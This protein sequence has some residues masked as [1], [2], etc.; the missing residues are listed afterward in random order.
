MEF[1]SL[2]GL[3]NQNFLLLNSEKDL[4]ASKSGFEFLV[5]FG[6]QKF[7]FEITNLYLPFENTSSSANRQHLIIKFYSELILFELFINCVLQVLG[8]YWASIIS[9]KPVRKDEIPSEIFEIS[10][11]PL[12]NYNSRT[13]CCW[14]ISLE[15]SSCGFIIS[16]RLNF[17]SILTR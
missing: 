14:K 9:R 2:I 6:I 15:R 1:K 11:Y 7:G 17:K 3:W 13:T 5:L 8:E 4:G 16:R 10:N 12:C